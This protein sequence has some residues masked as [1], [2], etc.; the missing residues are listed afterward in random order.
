MISDPKASQIKSWELWRAFLRPCSIAI[1]PKNWPARPLVP[2]NLPRSTLPSQKTLQRPA[3]GLRGPN[4]R[5]GEQA[6]HRPTHLPSVR[7]AV[8]VVTGI[9]IATLSARGILNEINPQIHGPLLK[10][11][12]K[13]QLQ[14]AV[15]FA[16]PARDSIRNV[17]GLAFAH[18]P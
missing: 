11:Y 10:R 9:P 5:V 18:R 4:L 13:S 8:L 2:A 17:Y 15:L 14:Q 1:M 16:L 12:G 6:G 7:L 3:R